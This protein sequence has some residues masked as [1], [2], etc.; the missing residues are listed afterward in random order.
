[1]CERL[2]HSPVI[3][4]SKRSY[5]F[6]PTSSPAVF[7]IWKLTADRSSHRRCSIKQRFLE[8]FNIV[9]ELRPATVL[10]K[11][12]LHNCFPVSFT[13]FLR[14]PFLQN[15]SWRLLL[16]RPYISPI[17]RIFINNYNPTRPV[18]WKHFR[19]SRKS[20]E[21]APVLYKKGCWEKCKNQWKGD[22]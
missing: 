20:S 8:I 6:L 18:S 17:H 9:A 15:T 10:N 7:Q 16:R 19:S 14:T 22:Q 11:R 2:L 3:S 5:W 13:K 4:F 12:F 21:V 1:M